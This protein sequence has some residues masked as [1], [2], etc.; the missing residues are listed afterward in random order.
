MGV[1]GHIHT[2]LWVPASVFV[3]STFWLLW[4]TLMHTFMYKYLCWNMF[5]FLG[6]IPSSRITG[7]CG[8]SL[9]KILRKCQTVFQSCTT[10]TPTNNVCIFQFLHTFTRT[11]FLGFSLQPSYMDMKWLWFS[12]AFPNLFICLWIFMYFLWRNVNSKVW[13]IFKPGY[14]VLLSFLT[15]HIWDSCISLCESDFHSFFLISIVCW[16]KSTGVPI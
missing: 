16:V 5:H 11:Y 10:Y 8:N 13:A 2:G 14:C 7:S 15:R 6:S 4:I 1:K 9:F 3:V 12:F